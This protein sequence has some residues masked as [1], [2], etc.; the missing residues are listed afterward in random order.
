MSEMT[1][2]NEQHQSI[3]YEMRKIFE[4]SLDIANNLLFEVA[5]NE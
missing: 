2:D 3:P 4:G 1:R 5:N